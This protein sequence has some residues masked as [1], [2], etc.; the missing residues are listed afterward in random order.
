VD[1]H[2]LIA[3]CAPRPLFIGGGSDSGDGYADPKG[4]AW[5]DPKGMFLAEIAAG[6]AYRLMGKKALATR[7]FPKPGTPLITGDLAWRQHDD[8]HSPQPN[9]QYFL[10][11]ASRYLHTPEG[12]GGAR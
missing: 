10:E 1:N 7:E 4:D 5:A 2:E 11:F 3:L 9:W 6:P 8:G 12:A